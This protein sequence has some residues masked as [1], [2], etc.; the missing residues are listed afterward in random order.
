MKKITFIVALL[1]CFIGNAQTTINGKV[2]DDF[3]QPIPGANIS[4][5][6]ESIGTVTNFDGVFTLTVT[7]K[8]PFTITASSIGYEE[9]SVEVTSVTE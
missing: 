2:V 1:M 5:K 6:G 8:P 3:N 7:K 9:S 4:L